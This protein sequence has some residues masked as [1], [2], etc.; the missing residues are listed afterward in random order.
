MIAMDID[1]TALRPDSTV[2]PRLVALVARLLAEGV[3]LVLA[4]GRGPFGVLPVQSL[5]GLL[6]Q[7]AVCSNGAVVVQSH[8]P[9]QQPQV[10]QGRPWKVLASHVFDPNPV[11]AALRREMP[12]VLFAAE[13]ETGEF[14]VTGSFPA[15]EITA[16][17]RLLEAG[18][19]LPDRAVRL[20]AR[21]P[22]MGVPDFA[23]H[24]LNAQLQDVNAFVGWTAWL[25]VAPAG[26]NKGT[27]LTELAQC[28]GIPDNGTIAFG[29][30]L[31]DLEMISWAHFGVAMA[32]GPKDLLAA[33]DAH[34]SS[35]SDDGVA[36]VLAALAEHYQIP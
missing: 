29:D 35:A 14:V 12:E 24:V 2:S 32:D 26:V 23:E 8:V 33:A 21:M 10:A 36:A 16:P 11:A 1:G 5:L 18:E 34:T 6:G 20:V 3:S 9:S 22:G 13:I 28:L 27:G 30:G 17:K 31:N 15:G 25:D 4:S 7:P 19:K